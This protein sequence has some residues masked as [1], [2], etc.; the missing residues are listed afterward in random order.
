LKVNPCSM[1]QGPLPDARSDEFLYAYPIWIN[2]SRTFSP[3]KS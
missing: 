2:Q 3:E 1:L